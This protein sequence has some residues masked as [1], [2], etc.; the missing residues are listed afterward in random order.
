MLARWS[1]WGAVPA[2]FDPDRDDF[3]EA[4]AELTQ[5]LSPADMAAAARSTL[6]A[7]YTDA[8]L[9]RAVW[10]G[11]G[12]LGFAGGSVLEPG[13]G[14]GN[15]IGFAP[16]G[17]WMVGVELDPTTAAIAQA[18]YPHAQILAESF[19]E[20]R[21]PEQSFDAA[22]GNVPFG[23]LALTDLRHNP[24]GHSIRNHFIVKALHLVRPGGMVAVV[25]SRYT[26]DSRNPAARR[27]MAN[28]ADLVG[29]V[30]LPTGAHQRAR[31]RRL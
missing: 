3:A 21:A 25:T 31:A 7:R 6:N 2:V 18:L 5:L 29:A 12:E 15:F 24:A 11:L 22:V 16:P 27:E 30:R 9:V 26:M 10:A 8:E 1:G 23:K 17:T 14:S 20:T 13:C 28:L 4:R 19:A